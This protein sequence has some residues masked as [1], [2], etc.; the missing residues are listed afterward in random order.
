M[1]LRGHLS[2]GDR[3]KTSG[4]PVFALPPSKLSQRSLSLSCTLNNGIYIYIYIYLCYYQK[5][6]C[7][8]AK[9]VVIRLICRIKSSTESSYLVIVAYGIQLII[10]VTQCQ[11]KY[12][13]K[14]G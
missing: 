5:E 3:N 12:P 11:L 7:N 10:G 4:S 9:C 6:L 13:T 8:A 14:L 2:H 1:L